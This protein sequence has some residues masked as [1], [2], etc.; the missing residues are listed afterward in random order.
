[1]E[2]PA[3]NAQGVSTHSVLCRE[4][5]VEAWKYSREHSQLRRAMV[6]VQEL[7]ELIV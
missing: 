1:M 3:T 4:A 5:L 2:E 6:G 7:T